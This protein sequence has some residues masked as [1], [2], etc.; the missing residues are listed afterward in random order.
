M[1]QAGDGARTMS[2]C[3]QTCLK[4]CRHVQNAPNLSVS[5]SIIRQHHQCAPCA[6]IYYS[7]KCG[8]QNELASAG[9]VCLDWGST[10]LL[11]LFAWWLAL[12][13]LTGLYL[14]VALPCITIAA[15]MVSSQLCKQ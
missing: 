5:G 8:P 13:A 12:Q 7:G 3:H 2:R 4:W 1:R 10:G 11:A 15:L 6:Y 9:A 14:V